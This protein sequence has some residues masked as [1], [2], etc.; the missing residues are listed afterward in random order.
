M[1]GQLDVDVVAAV[2]A[3]RSTP[4]EM[5]GAARLVTRLARDDADRAELLD[6]LGLTNTRT[7]EGDQ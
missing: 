1:R 7:T 2:C 4:A 3:D 6:A 5:E